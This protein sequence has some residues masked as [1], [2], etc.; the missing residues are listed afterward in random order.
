MEV[1]LL[2]NLP[3][4]S[5]KYVCHDPNGRYYYV[6]ISQCKSGEL[7]NT[8]FLMDSVPRVSLKEPMPFGL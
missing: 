3:K 5:M 2:E 1:H 7:V 8:K 6:R 4:I